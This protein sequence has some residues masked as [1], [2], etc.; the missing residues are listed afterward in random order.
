MWDSSPRPLTSL[1]ALLYS[2]YRSSLLEAFHLLRGDSK[3]A[4]AALAGVDDASSSSSSEDRKAS[5]VDSDFD[6]AAVPLFELRLHPADVESLLE[7]APSDAVREAW[8]KGRVA[9]PGDESRILLVDSSAAMGHW[10]GVS[11]TTVEALYIEGREW[12]EE[13]AALRG[14]A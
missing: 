11:C 10:A 9:C 12:W 13:H 3:S 2:L 1:I 5:P 4:A 8:R 7:A 14:G 6:E